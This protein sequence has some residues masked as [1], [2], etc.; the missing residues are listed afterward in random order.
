MV[1][2]HYLLDCNTPCLEEAG[3]TWETLA[4]PHRDGRC[5]GKPCTAGVLMPHGSSRG[6]P[7]AR[8]NACGGRV[9]LSSGTASSGLVTDQAPGE[10]AVRAVAEG[11]ALRATARLVQVDQETGCAWLNRG[12]RHGRR[13]RLSVWPTLHVTAGPLAAWWSVVQTKAAHRPGATLSGTPEGA[14]GVGS[15]GAPG[16]RLG[17]AGVLGKRA[18]ASADVLLARV[19]PVTDAYSPFVPSAQWPAYQHALLTTD[20]AWSQPARRGARGASPPPRRRPLPG[21]W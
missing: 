8:G 17:L 10:M 20:G 2:H 6:A 1:G 11:Q 16:W 21:L 18:H 7:Q 19:A 4:C 9:P 15:A 14:A 12:A 13:V 3:V 5:D